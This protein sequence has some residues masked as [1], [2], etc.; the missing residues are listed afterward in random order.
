MT[1]TFGC[2]RNASWICFRLDSAEVLR[3][4][5]PYGKWNLECEAINGKLM[6]KPSF[7]PECSAHFGKLFAFVAS[8]STR[9][10]LGLGGTGT[11]T[12]GGV[13]DDLDPNKV[14]VKVGCCC[15]GVDPACGVTLG[16]TLGSR[17]ME[18]LLLMTPEERRGVTPAPFE[19]GAPNFEVSGGE[20][21]V[22]GLEGVGLTGLLISP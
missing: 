2:F 1:W 8:S 9:V 13:L 6:G 14:D 19:V 17:R 11:A 20:C 16:V 12:L 10:D 21:C 22:G 7:P 4:G 5:F 3:T 15:F 18:L